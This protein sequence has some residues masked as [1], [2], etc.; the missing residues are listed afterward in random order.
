MSKVSGYSGIIEQIFLSKYKPGMLEVAFE[1]PQDRSPHGRFPAPSMNH[2][3]R[4]P[5]AQ[6][7]EV[8]LDSGLRESY[9]TGPRLYAVASEDRAALLFELLY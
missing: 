9:K 5:T 8:G 7:Q 3:H 4:W 6:L 1:R 2:D